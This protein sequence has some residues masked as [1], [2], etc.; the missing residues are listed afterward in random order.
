MY[1]VRGLHPSP[2]NLFRFL[3][4]VCDFKVTNHEIGTLMSLFLFKF[5]AVFF[6]LPPLTLFLQTPAVL[7]SCH[8]SDALT[9]VHEWMPW[10]SLLKL[11]PQLEEMNAYWWEIRKRSFGPGGD[12][13]PASSAT[14]ASLLKWP[15]VYFLLSELEY[16]LGQ[17]QT[18]L[19]VYKEFLSIAGLS[20]WRLS[21]LL[22]S[23]VS[24][25][26]DSQIW[27]LLVWSLWPL[28][29]RLLSIPRPIGRSPMSSLFSL[30]GKVC[31]FMFI[32]NLCLTGLCVA[33][34]TYQK[35]THQIAVVLIRCCYT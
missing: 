20:L 17:I 22:L 9:S 24:V 6:F 31:L 29:E 30:L 11:S 19:H 14:G 4:N 15:L 34:Q 12:L 27:P 23:S 8:D 16:S 3:L 33:Y 13:S 7:G 1:P 21:L 32:C 35:W 5:P 2:F 10:C 28:R 26:L 18:S 25:W